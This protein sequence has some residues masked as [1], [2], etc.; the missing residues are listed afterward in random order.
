MLIR[1]APSPT[2]ADP[3]CD[4]SHMAVADLKSL[5]P[6]PT[7]APQNLRQTLKTTKFPLT[8]PYVKNFSLVLTRDTGRLSPFQR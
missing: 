1:Y 6:P 5:L 4:P 2:S 8:Q 7:T 3:V